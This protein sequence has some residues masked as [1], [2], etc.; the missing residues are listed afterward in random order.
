MSHFPVTSSIL[1]KTHLNK[2]LIEQ[3]SLPQETETSLIKAGVAHTYL[4]NTGAERFVFRVYSLGWRTLTEINEEI[5]LLNL[6]HEHYIPVAYAVKDAADNY[7]QELNAPE[8]NRHGVMFVF[9]EGDKLHNSPEELHYKVGALMANLHKVTHNLKLGRITYTP[10]VLLEDSFEEL[11]MFLKPSPELDF[12]ETAQQQ[13]LNT[14]QSANT[15][16]MRQGVVHLDIWFDNISVTKNHRIS[17]YD[18]DFCGNGWLCLDIAYYV[19][20]L[21]SVERDEAICRGKVDSFLA[22]YESV[23]KISAEERRLLPYLGVA[24][25][26]FYL[27]VQ[28]NRFDNW[29]NVFINETYMKRFVEVLVKR[30]YDMYLLN[31]ITTY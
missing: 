27:G 14:L 28:S 13:L 2:F 3:Y 8:G 29:S 7:I 12:M 21:H 16:A 1:S 19:L 31:E 30:Y 24:L 22:G 5:R 6:L 11:K 10:K 26:F 4:V 20:Q 25:Y 15:T 18:F 23:I 9:V 17:L